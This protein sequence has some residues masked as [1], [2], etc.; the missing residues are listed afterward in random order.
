MIKRD[1]SELLLE[2]SRTFPAVALMGPRQCGKT[3]L[4]KAVFPH[5]PYV[6]LEDPDVRNAAKNDPRYFLGRYGDGAIFDEIQNVPDLMSY[7]QGIIDAN[8]DFMGRYV[9]T[10]SRQFALMEAMTQSLAGRIGILTLTPFSARELYGE[11]LSDVNVDEMIVKGMY[12]PVHVRKVRPKLWYSSYFQTY[13]ERDVRQILKVKDLSTFELFVRLLAGRT[14]QE[15]NLNSLGVDA[16][17]THTTAKAW[18]SV[19]EASGLVFKLPPYFKNYNKRLVSAPK[20]YFADTGLA[21]WLMGIETAEQ[22]HLNPQYGAIF[23]TA[24]VCECRKRS[25]NAGELPQMYFWRDNSK[26]EIDL[27][28]ED[29]DGP[30]P[31]EIK[32]G[33]TYR[34]EWSKP[35]R[36]WIA[37]TGVSAEKA[38]IVYGGNMRQRDN[39]IEVVPWYGI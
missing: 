31:I 1:I 18:I 35:M 23:E 24:M 28:L 15:L 37:A 34:S 7:L 17:V 38:K 8:P 4:A 16:G 2:M 11:N 33:M 22:L 12:P 20:L 32:S 36:R 30:H 10:G 25:L 27:I 19:L 39:D 14:G 6:S 21:C 26:L 5:L 9:L 29:R 3:T 13:L